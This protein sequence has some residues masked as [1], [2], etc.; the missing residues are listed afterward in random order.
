MSKIQS[1]SNS[2]PSANCLSNSTVVIGMSKIQSE[3]NSQHRP[4]GIVQFLCCD[5]YV[6]DTIWKQFT[7]LLHNLPLMLL[8]WSVCQRYNL[9]AIHNVSPLRG[10][11]N[12]VVIGMSK[13]QSESNSQHLITE[14]YTKGRLWSVCQRYNLKA[15]HNG[16][17]GRC[18][19]GYVVIGMS[20]IQ[21]ESNSQPISNWWIIAKGCDR[22]VKDTIWKQFT[23][24]DRNRFAKGSLWS[25][26]QRYNLKAIHNG[27]Q[28]QQKTSSVVIGMSKIQSESNSQQETK[29]ALK[30]LGCDRYVKDTIW[31]QFTT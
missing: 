30:D 22:Y 27:L 5:R 4:S 15:I 25:V 11:P 24:L 2:Q 8:L 20:K 9:K 26:C 23:T 13:I 19:N 14:L 12:D 31:K 3:S 1:E 29:V 21:S 6:K 7:T 10:S 17:N 18:I 28:G 16:Y